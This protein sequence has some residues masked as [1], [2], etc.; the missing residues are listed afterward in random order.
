MKSILKV[1][2]LSVC[3]LSSISIAQADDSLQILTDVGQQRIFLKAEKLL[4]KSNSQQ[5]QSLYN[6]LYYY[7]LQPYLDQRRLMENMQLSSAGEIATFLEK[8]QHS[9]LDWP[10][11]KAWLTYLSKRNKGALFLKFYQSSHNTSSNKVVVSG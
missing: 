10:L 9:P 5:Y 1:I 8:H 4:A 6:Q 11:R 2:L 7:P 3:M